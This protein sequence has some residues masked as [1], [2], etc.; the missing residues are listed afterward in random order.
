VI[1][2]GQKDYPK[3]IILKGDSGI[4]F[5]KKQEVKLLEKLSRLEKC[6]SEK[7]T[8]ISENEKLTKQLSYADNDYN[9][10]SQ[11]YFQLVD[12]LKVMQLQNE[13]L[14]ITQAQELKRWKKSTLCVS[15]AAAGILLG[16]VTGAWLP[17]VAVLAVT[18]AAIIFTKKKK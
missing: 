14:T 9:L 6:S 10:L 7:D 18:E 2:Y 8:L 4:F 5:T 15:V 3:R 12:T 1:V 11:R 17:A 16:G 13:V